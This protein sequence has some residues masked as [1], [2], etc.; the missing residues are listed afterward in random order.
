MK[1]GYGWLTTLNGEARSREGAGSAVASSTSLLH[2]KIEMVS[3]EFI[4]QRRRKLGT[5]LYSGLCISSIERD[6]C[7]GGRP[8]RQESEWMN[9]KCGIDE[10][11]DRREKIK[12]VVRGTGRGKNLIE[13]MPGR[14]VIRECLYV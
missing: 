11:R 7:G 12:R 8:E 3:G 9:A 5:S 14:H 6:G 2:P 1:S 4:D 10:A 13:P